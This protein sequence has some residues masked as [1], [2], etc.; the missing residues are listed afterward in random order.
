MYI[1][2]LLLYLFKDSIGF[3]RI[4]SLFILIGI[5]FWI[6]ASAYLKM[7]KIFSLLSGYQFIIYGF[8]EFTLTVFSKL[9]VH[10]FPQTA[11]LQCIVYIVLPFFIITGCIAGGLILHKVMP[12]FYYILTGGR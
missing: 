1:G 11:L 8:H 9:A 12:K 5:I 7:G 10:L 3:I 2:G 4:G 6:R